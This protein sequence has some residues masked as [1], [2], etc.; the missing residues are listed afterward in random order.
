MQ[1]ESFNIT[2]FGVNCFVSILGGVLGLV[3]AKL[4]YKKLNK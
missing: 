1:N 2:L 3:V 4:I